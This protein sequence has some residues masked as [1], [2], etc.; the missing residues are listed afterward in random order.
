MRTFQSNPSLGNGGSLPKSHGSIPKVVGDLGFGVYCVHE[1]IPATIT[2]A[3]EC[4][5]PLSNFSNA[6]LVL[7][8]DE[9]TTID[10]FL[11]VDQFIGNIC[12]PGRGDYNRIDFDACYGQAWNAAPNDHD[13]RQHR[14]PPVQVVC[15]RQLDRVLGLRHLFVELFMDWDRH[16]RMVQDN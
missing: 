13:N 15:V 8:P 5:L 1:D 6:A 3:I 10:Q 4:T 11:N 2:Y 16:A 9:E 14:A 7:F 12:N